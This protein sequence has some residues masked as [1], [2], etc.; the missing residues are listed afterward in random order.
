MTAA[1]LT[2]LLDSL[3]EFSIYVI[4][5]ETHKLLFFNQ[6]CRETSRGKAAVGVKCHEV[7]PEVCS[8]CPLDAKGAKS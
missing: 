6:R 3:I 2:N 5:E 8:N 1:D 4:E 7:W